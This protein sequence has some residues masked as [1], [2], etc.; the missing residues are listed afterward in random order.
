MIEVKTAADAVCNLKKCIV[1]KIILFLRFVESIIIISLTH[2]VIP[3]CISPASKLPSERVAMPLV[4]GQ[5]VDIEFYFSSLWT[6]QSHYFHTLMKRKN[7]QI[8][9]FSDSHSKQ[10]SNS[11]FIVSRQGYTTFYSAPA[12]FNISKF[13]L[14]RDLF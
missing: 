6:L 3:W 1:I 5:T 4:W 14:K 10:I 2:Q 7:N 8:V 12:L 13:I 9:L 11:I